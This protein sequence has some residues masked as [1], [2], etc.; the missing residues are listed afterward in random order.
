MMPTKEALADALH[1]SRAHL[2]H[3][4]DYIAPFT[5]FDSSM[6]NAW[7]LLWQAAN[8][9]AEAQPT[10][11]NLQDKQRGLGAD[12]LAR[13]DESMAALRDLRFFAAK[14]FGS[15]SAQYQ[16]F[17]FAQGQKTRH[18]AANH[19]IYMEL[20]HELAV[21]VQ[22]LLVARG[23]TVAQITA[24]STTAASIKTAEKAHE[25]QKR[26]RPLNT[27]ARHDAFNAIWAYMVQASDAAETV[28]VNEPE[29]RALFVVTKRKGSG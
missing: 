14:A 22:A 28:F 7:G 4:K 9:T 16:Q 12:V 13:V 1:Q 21:S 10:D 3:F 24:L 26:L 17:H 18:S 23:M 6:N 15:K 8:D 11:E 5:A 2:K 20:S 29:K 19:H 27:G 25:K